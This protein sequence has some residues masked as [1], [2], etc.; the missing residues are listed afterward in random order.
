MAQLTVQEVSKNSSLTPSFSA[1]SS[2]GDTFLNNGKVLVY[3]K[4]ANVGASR[5]ITINSLVD[6]NQGF[7]HDITVTIPQ[8]SEEMVGFFETDRFNNSSGQVSMTYDDESDLTIAA[9]RI[10]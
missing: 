2:E 7:D 5:T 6:C 8:S 9:I 3:A 1:A 10:A 4:N